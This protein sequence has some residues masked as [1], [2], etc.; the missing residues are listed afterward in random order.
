M[1]TQ[2]RTDLRI[3]GDNSATGGS[4]NNAKIIGESVINGNLDCLNFKCVGSSRIEGNMKANHAR[5]VGSVS[6][7]GSLETDDIRIAG[8]VDTNGDVKAA[9]LLLTGGLDIKGGVKSGNIRLTGYSTIKRNCEAETFRS[10]GPLNIGGLLTADDV[11]IRIHSRCRVS[12][13]GG[14]RICARRGHYSKL[15][16]IIKSLF[17]PADYFKGE[18]VVDSIEGDDI[19]LED[20]K[21]RTVRGKN[22][23]IGEG[24][25]ID[26]LE[27]TGECRING[28]S[29]VKE[30]KKVQ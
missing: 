1:R 14:E 2:T 3:I 9:N 11:D 30:K 4:Y 27:Y 25:E 13:I 24:C 22:V 23:V 28:R 8:N 29:M 26:S 7:T 17:I 6:I 20:T 10:E 19:R 5:I 21:A 12:E 15:R 16:N 18:L